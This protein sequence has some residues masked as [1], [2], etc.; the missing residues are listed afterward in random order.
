MTVAERQAAYRARRA[1][2]IAAARQEALQALQALGNT[3][4]PEAARRRLV[5]R[6]RELVGV[7][8][9]CPGE[10]ETALRCT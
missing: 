1:A 3:S 6:L 5:G 8:A 7:L 9:G 10:S 2:R 4:M